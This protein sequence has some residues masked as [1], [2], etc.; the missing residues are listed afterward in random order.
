MSESQC[1]FPDCSERATLHFLEVKNRRIIEEV[2]M[3]NSHGMAHV[4]KHYYNRP[5]TDSVRSA[6]TQVTVPFDIDCLYWDELQDRPNGEGQLEL[7]EV[8]GARSLEMR[9]D[10]FAW[11]MIRSELSGYQFPR[12]T[13]HRAMAAMLTALGARLRQV[14]IDK[15]VPADIYVYHS[16]LNIE[17]VNG[18]VIVDLRPTDALTLALIC[19][20]PV[21]VSSSLL[22]FLGKRN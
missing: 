8:G 14:E 19:E 3:C 22:A 4:H 12:P 6:L 10:V 21:F 2:S 18:N 16:K 7:L 20:S 17:H 1:Q 15:A 9:V 5:K 11:S 13:T